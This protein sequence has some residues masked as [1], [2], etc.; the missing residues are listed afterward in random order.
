MLQRYEGP[1]PCMAPSQYAVMSSPAE[2]V[3]VHAVGEAVRGL[4]ARVAAFG[5]HQVRECPRRNLQQQGAHACKPRSHS[6]SAPH[7]GIDVPHEV[8]TGTQQARALRLIWPK[9]LQKDGAKP[10]GAKGADGRN[11]LL[12]RWRTWKKDAYIIIPALKGRTSS[13]S[14][15]RI[16]DWSPGGRML[17]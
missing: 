10:A 9:T 3:G 1:M 14:F 8:S 4:E 13:V 15:S 12:G 17:V 5:G 16:P 11:Q 2:R 7:Q 6:A